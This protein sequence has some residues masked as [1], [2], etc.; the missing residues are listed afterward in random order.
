MSGPT[1]LVVA[2][3]MGY[4]PLR[5]AFALARALGA[6]VH[7]IDRP[8]LAGREEAKLWGRTRV[9]YEGLTRVS[10]LP[11]AGAPLRGVLETLTAIPHLHPYRNLSGPTLGT[12][13]LGWLIERGLGHGMMAQ[14]GATGAN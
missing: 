11:V 4:G 2:I 10:Q 6:Q 1:P 12:R 13:A 7:Q 14:L 8:P 9:V 3:E 5:P